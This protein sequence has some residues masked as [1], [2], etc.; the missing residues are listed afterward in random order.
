MG[1]FIVMN[2]DIQWVW[3]D[4][5]TIYMLA[6]AQGSLDVDAFIELLRHVGESFAVLDGD[7]I[8]DLRQARWDFDNSATN[9]IAAG[10]PKSGLPMDNKIALVCSR[11]IDHYGQLL[12]IASGASNRGFRVRAFY[13]PDGALKWLRE[14]WNDC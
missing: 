10:F 14:Q 12:V 3:L 11:D 6:K 4:D 2:L 1:N 9:A 5:I 13:D 8:I 7:A